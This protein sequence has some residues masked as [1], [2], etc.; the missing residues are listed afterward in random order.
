MAKARKKQ[1]GFSMDFDFDG[2]LK[3]MKKQE[4][5]PKSKNNFFSYRKEG[6]YKLRVLPP[7]PNQLPF[8]KKLLHWV[9]REPVLCLK[10]PGSNYGNCPLC[11]VAYQAY[12]D[13][14]KELGSKIRRK[15][16]F[17][18][19]VIDRGSDNNNPL[20]IDVPKSIY[21]SLYELIIDEDWNILDPKQGRD[22][23]L[24]KNG[25]G[26]YTK[27]SVTAS[28][29]Q[30]PIF[31]DEKEIER[32]VDEKLPKMEFKSLL[33]FHSLEEVEKIAEDLNRKV[34]F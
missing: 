21:E 17:I 14:D 28:P 18:F 29:K 4:G 10:Q 30:T 12:A 26:L 9:N 5:E 15:E 20:F 11:E 24:I 2:M 13:G 19:R 6:T 34:E 23:T 31:D 3:E 27:Y 16:R 7:L 22:I 32:L 8:L 33:K 25:E 1:E